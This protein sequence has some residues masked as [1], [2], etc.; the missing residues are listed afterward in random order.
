MRSD[1]SEQRQIVLV[2]MPCDSAA[3]GLIALG[4]LIKDL[5]NPNANNIDV[6]YES[7]LKYA[8]QYL[9]SCRY[10][11]ACRPDKKKCGYTS[12]AT[13]KVR[14]WN[15]KKPK[16]HT[17]SEETDIQEKRL[18]LKI[19]NGTWWQDPKRS[20]SWQIVGEP[21]PQLDKE[22]EALTEEPY[23]H[24]INNLKIVSENL[25]RSFSG[26]CFAGRVSGKEPTRKI[27]ASSIFINGTKEYHLPDLLTIHGWRRSI[28]VSRMSF[29]NS[30]TERFDRYSSNPSLVVAD[31]DKTF[32]KILGNPHFQRSDVIGVINRVIDRVDNSNCQIRQ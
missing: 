23:K 31:G 25:H 18:L 4:A 14:S 7:L 12:K 22:S 27:L 10:C 11:K 9:Q 8:N 24:I 15:D 13:G 2:S 6:H 30:R 32:L 17:I 19:K 29:F 16:T 26:L 5:E 3:A 20:T 1:L 21:P 28:S